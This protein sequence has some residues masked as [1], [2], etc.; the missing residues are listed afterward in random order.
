M[1]PVTRG[2]VSVLLRWD[3]GRPQDFDAVFGGDGGDLRR[4]GGLLG[5][6]GRVR[7]GAGSAQVRMKASKPPG[8]VTSRKLAP[9]VE[10]TV[11]VCGVPWGPNTNDPVGARIT[12]PPTQMV[13]SPS[14]M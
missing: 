13:S 11:K 4:V 3:A 10:L 6:G 12:W 5:G 1:L 14:R 2:V 7:D 8:S 9:P